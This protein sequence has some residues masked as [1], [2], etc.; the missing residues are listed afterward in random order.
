MQQV[1]LKE[2][3]RHGHSCWLQ[4]EGDYFIPVS[5]LLFGPAENLHVNT[6]C[7]CPA[8]LANYQK[9]VKQMFQEMKNLFSGVGCNA[10][11]PHLLNTPAYGGKPVLWFCAASFLCQTFC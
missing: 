9:P 8:G 2:F 3:C 1:V 5:I 6:E 10:S 4:Q 7:P 11:T